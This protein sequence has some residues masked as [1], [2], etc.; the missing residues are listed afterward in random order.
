MMDSPFSML[1]EPPHGPSQERCVQ[2]GHQ[3]ERDAQSLT[4]ETIFE[5]GWRPSLHTAFLV[6]FCL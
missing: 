5:A 3:I 4:W 6:D 1:S 2:E